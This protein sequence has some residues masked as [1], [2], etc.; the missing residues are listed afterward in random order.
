MMFVIAMIF[1]ELFNTILFWCV[2]QDVAKYTSLSYFSLAQFLG[3]VFMINIGM[4]IFRSE[5]VYMYYHE[6]IERLD[7]LKY[8]ISSMI[9][10]IVLTGFYYI[11][12]IFM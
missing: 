9:A 2:Y 4:A 3:I 11:C 10:C 5:S 6:R 7:R 1:A 12:K 8:K